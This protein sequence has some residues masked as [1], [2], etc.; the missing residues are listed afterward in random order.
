MYTR[1]IPL[2]ACVRVCVRSLLIGC[3]FFY[4]PKSCQTIAIPKMGKLSQNGKLRSFIF[5]YDCGCHNICTYNSCIY[6]NRLLVYCVCVCVCLLR[7]IVYCVCVCDLMQ[8]LIGVLSLGNLSRKPRHNALTFN[9]LRLQYRVQIGW[10]L[11]L[12]LS[13]VAT[14]VNT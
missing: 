13:L 9:H 7:A 6:N 11:F 1:R 4:V 14:N 2:R 8:G 10:V 12:V 3:I 5:I